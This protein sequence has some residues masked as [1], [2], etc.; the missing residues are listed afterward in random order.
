MSPGMSAPALRRAAGRPRVARSAT[1][2]RNGGFTFA[3]RPEVEAPDAR[4]LWRADLDPGTL[5][6]RAAP[7]EA[8]HPDAI[9]MAVLAPW[10]TIVADETGEHAVLSDGWRHIRID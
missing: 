9:D 4:I 10:L 7:I 1:I 3:E 8:D 2:W 6:V 5:R